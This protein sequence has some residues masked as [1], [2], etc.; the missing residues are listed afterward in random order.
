MKRIASREEMV[1]MKKVILLL[2]VT[3]FLAISAAA[4]VLASS[5]VIN[6]QAVSV[7]AVFYRY[8]VL[9][10]RTFDGRYAGQGF[11]VDDADDQ[12]VGGDADDL[13]DGR[14]NPDNND[15]INVIP[16]GCPVRK[17]NF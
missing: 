7:S 4:P 8:L 15:D 5:P 10:I 9:F 3:S 2:L 12:L 14:I 16:P 11:T 13:A 6:H 17:N 1:L